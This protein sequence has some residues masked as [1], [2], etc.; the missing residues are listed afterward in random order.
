MDN[1]LQPLNVQQE[2]ANSRERQRL[3]FRR[4]Q[5]LGLL[6]VALGILVYRLL[7]IPSG[8]LFHAGWWRLW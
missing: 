7:Q 2:R 6:V 5:Y 3:L 8:T 4:N 1:R